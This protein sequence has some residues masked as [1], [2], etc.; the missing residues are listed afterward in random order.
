M[1]KKQVLDTGF[2]LHP[3][4]GSLNERE[5]L[6][7]T[8]LAHNPIVSRTGIYVILSGTISGGLRER[9][10]TEEVKRTMIKLAEKG[11]IGYDPVDHI[12]YIK[13]F[14]LIFTPFGSGK[15]EIIA[16]DLLIDF[17]NGMQF[18]NKFMK[19]CW[20]NYVT[21]NFDK[22]KEMD[23]R[24]QRSKSKLSL[25]KLLDLKLSFS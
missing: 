21:E 14:H 2:W 11:C 10:N 24:L 13:K 1:A 16:N 20:Q 18:P 17:E 9:I 19:E 22:L 8:Y 3:F 7:M 23:D 4:L 25:K 5:V 6:L 15:P 12:V